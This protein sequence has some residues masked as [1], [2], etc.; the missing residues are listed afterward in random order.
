ECY[1]GM[2]LPE[3]PVFEPADVRPIDPASLKDPADPSLGAKLVGPGQMTGSTTWMQP[4]GVLE[5]ALDVNGSTLVLPIRNARITMN[6]LGTTMSVDD[7]QMGGIVDIDDLVSV[8]TK[9]AAAADPALCD[10]NGSAAQLLK[11]R[12]RAMADVIHDP[13]FGNKNCNGVSIGIGFSMNR[14]AL[15]EPAAPLPP[16][17]DVCMP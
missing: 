11:V 10:P 9:F 15:G 5:L 16:P 13:M 17:P 3:L 14:S 6:I 2:G 4:E 8:V 12:I 1:R 7:G